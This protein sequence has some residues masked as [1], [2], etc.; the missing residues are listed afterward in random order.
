MYMMPCQT[1]VNGVTSLGQLIRELQMEA[2]RICESRNMW[3]N[4]GIDSNSS[5][6]VTRS[7]RWRLRP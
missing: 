6:G 3:L 1:V 4:S 7:T 2:G 5:V